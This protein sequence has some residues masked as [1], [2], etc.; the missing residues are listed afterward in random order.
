MNLTD[1]DSYRIES[2][3][4]QVEAGL[5]TINSTITFLNVASNESAI[6][7]CKIGVPGAASTDAILVTIGKSQ[8]QE[9]TPGLK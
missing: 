7:R 2:N 5:Y 1:G 6:V 9:Y 3:I 4:S 8:Y